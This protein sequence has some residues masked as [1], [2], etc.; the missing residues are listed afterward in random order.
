[1]T[2]YQFINYIY[3]NYD[4][5]MRKTGNKIYIED[6][7]SINNVTRRAIGEEIT[8]FLKEENNQNY[9]FIP[10]LQCFDSYRYNNKK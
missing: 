8:D 10:H 7:N 9:D 6:K 3:T 4:V 2:I 5:I 1:M